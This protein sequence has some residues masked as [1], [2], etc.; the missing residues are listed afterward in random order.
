MKWLGQLL[1]P[2]LCQRLLLGTTQK[3]SINRLQS[4]QNTF[5]RVLIGQ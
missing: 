5:V 3:Y 2:K 4:V 1:P